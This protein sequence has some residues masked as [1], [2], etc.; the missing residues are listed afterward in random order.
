MAW[1]AKLVVLLTVMLLAT[2]W[3]T[4]PLRQVDPLTPTDVLRS[5]HLL[6]QTRATPRN[7]LPHRTGERAQGED[8][9]RRCVAHGRPHDAVSS[10]CRPAP[11]HI[12]EVEAAHARRRPLRLHRAAANTPHDDEDAPTLLPARDRARAPPAPTA[13]VA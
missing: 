12:A 5:T 6:L 3:A 2:G 10:A 13:A 8:R 11:E 4:G 7:Q 1:R 9:T